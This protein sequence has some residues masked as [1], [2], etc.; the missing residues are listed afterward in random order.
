MAARQGLDGLDGLG[1]LQV[2]DDGVDHHHSEDDPGVDPLAQGGRHR[3]GDDQDEDQRLVELGQ[4]PAEG[5]H[6]LLRGD[7]VGSVLGQPRLDFGS[8]QAPV[9]VGCERK[10]GSRCDLAPVK[11]SK[12]ARAGRPAKV[13]SR[14]PTVRGQDPLG[15]PQSQSRNRPGQ[16]PFRLHLALE[17]GKDAFDHQAGGGKS[18]LEAQVGERCGPGRA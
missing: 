6:A 11:G 2:A 9:Q 18:P 5:A 17:V 7:G 14:I 15:D 4:R 10:R 3:P 1:L 13:L 12:R 8:G 16:V